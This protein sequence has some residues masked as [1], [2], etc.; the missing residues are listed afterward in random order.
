MS[1]ERAA[2]NLCLLYRNTDRTLLVNQI[3]SQGCKLQQ[4]NHNKTQSPSQSASNALRGIEILYN[5]LFKLET[6][7]QSKQK[8]NNNTYKLF[9]R[10]HP[11]IHI[12]QICHTIDK[13]SLSRE[14]QR[15]IPTITC[16]NQTIPMLI[17]STVNACVAVKGLSYKTLFYKYF[18]I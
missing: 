6:F 14:V 16:N 4:Q 5:M 7:Q 2:C 10:K 13:I 17:I 3:R 18:G 1:I 8:W 11:H 9:N 12:I 15:T